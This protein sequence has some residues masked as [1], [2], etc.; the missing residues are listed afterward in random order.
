MTANHSRAAA[1]LIAVVVCAS[2]VALAHAGHGHGASSATSGEVSVGVF[3]DTSV[4]DA[5]AVLQGVADS[6]AEAPSSF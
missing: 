1:L 2:A 6:T 5:G 4:P 3:G